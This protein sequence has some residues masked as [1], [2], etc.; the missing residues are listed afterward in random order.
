MSAVTFTGQCTDQARP[1]AAHHALLLHRS[2]DVCVLAPVPGRP[3]VDVPIA[4]IE[5]PVAQQLKR[6]QV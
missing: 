6:L 1:S 2:D 4:Q 5:A 3:R